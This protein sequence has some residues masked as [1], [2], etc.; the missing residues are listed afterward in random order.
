MNRDRRV[1]NYYLLVF[2]FVSIVLLSLPLTSRVRAFRAFASYLYD[3]LP[4]YGGRGLLKMRELPSDVARLIDADARSRQME[5]ELKETALLRTE[6]EA[7]RR[8]SERLSHALSL[9]TAAPEGLLWA[10]VVE[11]DPQNWQRSL[12]VD[13][14][15]QE[16]VAVNE[17]VLAPHAG[18]LGVVGRIT[19][20]G[21]H[22]AKVLLLSDE[23]SAVA[24]YLPASQWEGLV[25]GQGSSRLKMNY[26]PVEAKVRIGDEVAT[27]PTSATFPPD[28]PIG[29]VSR[30]FERDPFLA[31]Q[32]VEVAAL[33]HPGALKEVLILRRKSEGTP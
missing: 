23:L 13:A 10:H 3:P 12:I 9:S 28:L 18:R 7:L 15:E 32:T 5:A 8:E 4:Y 11:R 20:V 14:G 24:A 1:A 19:E 33:V 26:L 16:G 17:P 31:F 6:V 25:Q 2:G 27:S 29:T 22:T 21:R 30:A